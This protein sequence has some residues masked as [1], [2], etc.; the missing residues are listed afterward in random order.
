MGQAI[1]QVVSFGAGVALSPLPIIAVVLMLGT[2]RGR[3]NGPAFLGG[4][5]LGIAVLG[6]V[7]LLVS[8]GAS[9]SKHGSPAH[10]VSILKLVLGGLLLLL[11]VRRWRDRSQRTAT[12][13]LPGWMRT[14]DRFTPSRSAAMGAG[15][16]ALNPKNLV[17][18]VGAAAAIAQTGAST[19]S[20]AVALIVFIAI[21]TLGVGAPVAID[22]LMGDRA[23]RILGELRDWMSR[24]NATIIAIICV[25]IGA[26]LIGDGISGLT[27]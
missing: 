21:A 8:S 18:V 14:I 17:L 25:L 7:V 9:A 10:W 2:P 4:W 1:G 15:L 5:I 12:P 26:K 24:E 19:A 23:S 6:T 27:M 13:E 16:S 20:Q 3:V 22:H 11:A